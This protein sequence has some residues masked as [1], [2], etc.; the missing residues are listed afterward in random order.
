MSTYVYFIVLWIYFWYDSTYTSTSCQTRASVII[1]LSNFMIWS[2]IFL[3]Y[4]VVL[5]LYNCND[6]VYEC[7]C[8]NV[9]V[10][11]NMNVKSMKHREI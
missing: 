2:F 8:I 6:K 3:I 4:C 7:V 11:V 5:Q 9:T 10:N 1:R